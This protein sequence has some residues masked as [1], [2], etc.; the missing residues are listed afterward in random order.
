MPECGVDINGVVI[1]ALQRTR[2][3]V[4]DQA[5]VTFL[6]PQPKEARSV[7]SENMYTIAPGNQNCT[8]T[9]HLASTDSAS[10]I[11]QPY[12]KVSIKSMAPA[13][14]GQIRG[15]S[16]GEQGNFNWQ[17]GRKFFNISVSTYFRVIQFL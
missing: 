16:E 3:T 8:L 9:S 12:T 6:A 4:T 7:Y 14:H 2:P 10:L 5:S 17:G 15:H 1:H 13:P 11:E